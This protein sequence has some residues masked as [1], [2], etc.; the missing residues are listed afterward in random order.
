LTIAG[1]RGEV[2]RMPDDFLQRGNPGLHER[3]ATQIGS[4]LRPAGSLVI[5][6]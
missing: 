2:R 5:T 1:R 6:G 3:V 4:L